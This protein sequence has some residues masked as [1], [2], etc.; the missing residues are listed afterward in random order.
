VDVPGLSVCRFLKKSKNKPTSNTNK[1]AKNTNIP[2]NKKNGSRRTHILKGLKLAQI[3]STA[4]SGTWSCAGP[5]NNDMVPWQWRALVPLK[6]VKTPWKVFFFSPLTTSSLLFSC[7]EECWVM[8]VVQ[9]H[10]EQIF[11]SIRKIHLY[12]VCVVE[13]F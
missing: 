8:L 13:R 11:L 7:Q 4:N 12:Q 9:F 2:T 6:R 10:R 3:K 5:C 1:L